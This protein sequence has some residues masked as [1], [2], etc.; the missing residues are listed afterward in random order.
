MLFPNSAFPRI[1][2]VWCMHTVMETVNGNWLL[3]YS[4]NVHL[5][6]SEIELESHKIVHKANKQHRYYNCYAIIFL[7]FSEKYTLHEKSSK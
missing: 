1:L 6:R 3:Q 5:K 7:S 2:H 4:Q